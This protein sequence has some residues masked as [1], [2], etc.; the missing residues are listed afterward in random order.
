ML[1][2]GA[3]E[4]ENVTPGGV[5]C[6][7]CGLSCFSAPVGKAPVCSP[8]QETKALFLEAQAR[9]GLGEAEAAAALLARVLARDPA[10]EMAADLA[11]EVEAAGTALPEAEGS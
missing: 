7:R 11:G 10:H 9:W 4:R 3:T 8:P 2:T 1:R 6:R 5:G